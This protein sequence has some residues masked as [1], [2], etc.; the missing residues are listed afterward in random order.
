MQLAGKESMRKSSRDESFE[1]SSTRPG[2]HLTAVAAVTARVG[3]PVAPEGRTAP[4]SRCSRMALSHLEAA[5]SLNNRR[6][7]V[8]GQQPRTGFVESREPLWPR[9]LKASARR[10]GS[11]P[12]V[13]SRV[14]AQ[15]LSQEL[16]RTVH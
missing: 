14:S 16:A 8:E 6:S 7:R 11:S 15:D 5:R 10:G 4:S 2:D 1:W 12:R 13:H 3:H 9:R